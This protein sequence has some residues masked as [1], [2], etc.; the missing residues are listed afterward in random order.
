MNTQH[1]SVFMKIPFLGGILT[2]WMSDISERSDE[3]LLG[4]KKSK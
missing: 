4:E 2:R 1:T 3:A